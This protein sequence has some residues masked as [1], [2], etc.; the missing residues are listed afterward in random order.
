MME[1]T[2]PRDLVITRIIVER[3]RWHGRPARDQRLCP[4]SAA[5]STE[6]TTPFG[7]KQQRREAWLFQ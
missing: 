5:G 2:A 7:A 4:A 3:M 1:N 6:K